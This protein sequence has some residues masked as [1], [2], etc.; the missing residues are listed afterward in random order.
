MNLQRLE[1]QLA[2]NFILFHFHNF[3]KRYP[4]KQAYEGALN[5]FIDAR[6]PVT[7]EMLLN[8]SCRNITH[9]VT[10]FAEYLYVLEQATMP[11]CACAENR[12]IAE[13]T[14]R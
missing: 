6:I 12:C 9:V 4:N 2:R 7:P 11:H 8:C 1:L 5:N 10:L 13:L 14:T 3:G